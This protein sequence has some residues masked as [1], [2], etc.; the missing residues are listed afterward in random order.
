M[1]LKSAEWQHADDLPNDQM[2]EI[3]YN[4]LTKDGS[5]KIGYSSGKTGIQHIFRHTNNFWQI[6]WA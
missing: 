5:E 6:L 1:E 4:F 3:D 2:L